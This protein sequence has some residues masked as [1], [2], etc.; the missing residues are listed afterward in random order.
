MYIPS[1]LLLT[2]YQSFYVSVSSS[3]NT[4][5]I[6]IKQAHVCEIIF[7]TNEYNTNMNF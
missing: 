4:A 6:K 7:Q 2:V 5:T 1:L 3:C